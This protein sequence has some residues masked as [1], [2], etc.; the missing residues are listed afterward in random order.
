MNIGQLPFWRWRKAGRRPTLR[1]YDL[2]KVR[3]TSGD[4]DRVDGHPVAS[5]FRGRGWTYTGTRFCTWVLGALC[6]MWV[7]VV[8]KYIGDTSETSRT[9]G[10]RSI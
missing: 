10:G 7:V 2:G 6:A 8:G 1:L 5:P 3:G 9:A 4:G